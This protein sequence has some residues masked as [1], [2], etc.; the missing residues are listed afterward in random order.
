[1]DQLSVFVKTFPSTIK[2]RFN[3]IKKTL[4]HLRYIYYVYRMGSYSNRLLNTIHIKPFSYQATLKLVDLIGY[5]RFSNPLI[6]PLLRQIRFWINLFMG[7]FRWNQFTGTKNNVIRNKNDP[8]LI[9][10]LL[11]TLKEHEQRQRDTIERNRLNSM[12]EGLI[13]TQHQQQESIDK[14]LKILDNNHLNSGTTGSTGEQTAPLIQS[15]STS[16]TQSM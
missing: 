4:R 11:K 3:E 2:N 13:K 7:N 15:P 10:T 1:M 6:N 9:Q 16:N 14:I 8:E 5:R 12:L